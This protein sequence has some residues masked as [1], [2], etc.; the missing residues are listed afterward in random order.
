[1]QDPWIGRGVNWAE[2]AILVGIL[3]LAGMLAVPA[4]RQRG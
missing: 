2:T 1:M 4:L 3:A